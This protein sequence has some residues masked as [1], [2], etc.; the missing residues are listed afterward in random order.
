LTGARSILAL[1]LALSSH[2]HAE[3]STV[4]DQTR[5]GW[6]F[7]RYADPIRRGGSVVAA[8]ASSTDERMSAIVRCWSATGEL[9]RRLVLR[10]GRQFETTDVTWQLDRRRPESAHWL[11]SQTG[12]AV[13]APESIKTSLLAGMRTGSAMVISM[14]GDS[15][16]TFSLRG[17]AQAI[18]GVTKV[19]P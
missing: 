1:A 8:Q 3:E 19:C 12:N 15:T 4:A 10:D 14:D 18:G 13:V 2:V 9:D 5:A 7:E 17:S 6:S 11:R 16:F